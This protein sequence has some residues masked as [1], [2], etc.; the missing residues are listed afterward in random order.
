MSHHPWRLT[1]CLCWCQRSSVALNRSN[2][3]SGGT[4]TSA[5]LVVV[6]VARSRGAIACVDAVMFSVLSA[7]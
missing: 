7:V 3:V 1:G 4:D 5:A 6:W 2:H